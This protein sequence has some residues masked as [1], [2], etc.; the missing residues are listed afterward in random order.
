MSGWASTMV[1]SRP[2]TAPLVFLLLAGLFL[3]GP[4]RAEQRYGLGTPASEAEIAGWDIDVRPDGLGLPV[5]SGSVAEGEAIYLERCAYCHG[6]FGE[7]FGRYP[8][9]M[10]GE[11][12][13]AKQDPVKT[14]GSYWPYAS[15]VWDYVHRAMPF[16][17]AQ[18]LTADETYAVV[19]YLLYLNYLVEDDFV[20]TRDNL[21]EVEMPNAQG[22]F[23]MEGPEFEPREPCMT[24]CKDAVEVIGR[25]RIIDVTP[26]DGAGSVD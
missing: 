16:G 19:A 18:S 22:F 8:P 5:G 6:E 15:T 1:R 2:A 21:A 26:E 7:A 25:A 10:G 9:L 13:L 11:D 17:D 12:T 23:V 14:I 20:L 4:A 3:S 24:D